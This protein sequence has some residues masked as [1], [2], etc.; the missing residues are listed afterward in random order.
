MALRAGDRLGVYEVISLLGSGGMGEVYRARDPK[1]NRAIAVKVL[2]EATAADPDRRARFEREAQS[3]AALSHPNIVTIYS[4]EE[5]DGVLFLTMEYVEGK[6][7]CDLIVK[8][9]LPLTQI[10]SLAIPLADAVSTAHQRGIT[11]RDLKPAN[12]MVTADGRVKVLDFGLAKLMEASP[13]EMGVTGLPTSPLSGEGRIVG[14]VAYM[15]PEQAEGKPLDHRSDLFSLG[16]MLYELATG[17]RPFKGDTSVSV[18]SSIIK[19]TPASVADLRPT[20]P[21]ELSRIVKRCLVKDAD[22]RYQ[23]AKDLRNELE[24]LKHDVDSG[25]L[26]APATTAGMSMPI[27]ATHVGPRER[28][29]WVLAAIAIIAVLAGSIWVLRRPVPT[30]SLVRFDVPTPA[31]Y[32]LN[33]F[34]LSPDGG[35][36]VFAA[37]AEGVPKLWV[38]RFEETSAHAL[39]GTEGAMYPFW[40]P[41]GGAIGFFADAKLKRIDIAGR[42]LHVLTDAPSGRGGTW[43]RDGVI[44]FTPVGLT[45]DPTSVVMQIPADGGTPMPVTHLAAGQA[46]HRWPQ[47][48]PDGRRFLFFSGFGSPDTNGV[49]L[50]ALDGRQPIRLLPTE[51]PALFTPPDTLLVVRQ[52]AIRAIRFD[53]ERGTTSGQSVL[54]ADAVGTDTAIAR[55]AFSVALTGVLAYRPTGGSQRRQLVWVDRTGTRRGT[56]GAPDDN[57]MG[58]PE[59]DPTGQRL[60]VYRFLGGNADVWM[61]DAHLGGA[62]RLTFDP[63][64]EYAG[65]WSADGRRVLFSSTRSGTFDVF[66][67]PASGG[68]EHL[69]LRDAGI[70]V[71]ASH[72]GR[73]LLFQRN[74]L[75]TGADLWALPLTGE[76]KPFPVVQTMF[77]ERAGQFSPDDRWIAYQSNESGQFE[78]YIRS[79]PGIGGQ[80]EVST[81]GGTQPR[82][83]PD[84]KELYY[85]AP[86]ARLMA[87]PVT[88]S[89]G[90]QTLDPGAPVPLFPTRLA[91]G[92]NVVTGRSQ[93]MVAPDGQFLLNAVVDESSASPITV[94]LNWQ[95]E[96]KQRVPTR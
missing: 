96:L 23:T 39:P 12:V 67:K 95:E 8:G 35:Q 82:W 4:V 94:V 7:L 49:Y 27:P 76:P 41:D 18:I 3:I 42:A 62:T 32:D 20:V 86:D 91:S 9:G 22:R 2:P 14:T 5:A 50:G 31:S 66:E 43:S 64:V 16:V 46:S 54:V 30:Q 90:G 24:E 51:T 29:A 83:R 37:G 61:M 52:G 28:L 72:D 58:D 68:E 11:H 93:Y 71:S 74:D 15:S 87:V 69:V 78:I 36:L 13:V 55:S 10:L 56:V 26:M 53:P 19:D 25:E 1:L 47:F 45:S 84:G 75:K 60:V 34:A 38:R 73:F 40:S 77:D 70:P 65:V 92:A 88:A 17:E 48:L 85:V 6:P 57:G 21:R 89:D 44:L 80:L 81:R 79:F 63:A 33:S 59:L